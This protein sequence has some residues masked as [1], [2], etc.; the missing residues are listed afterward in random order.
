M[1]SKIIC[2]VA[3]AGLMLASKGFC[4][5]TGPNEVVSGTWGKANTQFGLVQGDTI[6]YDRFPNTFGVTSG[7][8]VVVGDSINERIVVF[9]GNGSFSCT[10]SN[11]VTRKL[12]PYRVLVGSSGC[13]VVG[14]VEF[15]HTFNIADCS[16]KGM[17]SNMGGA[18]E[19]N[20]DCSKIYVER[21]NWKIYSPT[22]TLISTSPT[23]PLELGQVTEKRI[24]KKEYQITVKY[25]D[26][27][28]VITS[29]KSIGYGVARPFRDT[30]G[31][32]YLVYS[33]KVE[34]YDDKGKVVS[35]LTLP[36][37]EVDYEGVEEAMQAG[38]EPMTTMKKGYGSP[39]VAP[40]GDVYT[41]MRSDTH[42]KILKWTW[43][44]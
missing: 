12:W 36:E 22:G 5:W 3:I 30:N 4:E 15:T 21:D 19:V 11:P 33:K 35:T 38:V 40:N 42:Y 37:D 17:A 28:W 31:K 14:Y 18:S 6:A 20:N 13:A 23:R 43:Q 32:L 41:W 39:I 34:R 8:K 29:D 26:K 24:G 27:E 25:P 7:G 16:L 1:K 2:L 44:D 9:N 10:I